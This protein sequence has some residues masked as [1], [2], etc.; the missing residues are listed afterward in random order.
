MVYKFNETLYNE[1]IVKVS[2]G[3][4]MIPNRKL[5]RVA[6]NNYYFLIDG[7]QVAK[8]PLSWVKA[9]LKKHHISESELETAAQVM[10]ENGDEVADFGIRGTL[11]LTQ[12]FEDAHIGPNNM[13]HKE[14]Q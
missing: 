5:V 7:I 2:K 3:D 4:Y 9:Q 8:G 6:D 12:K 11:I 1:Y 10:K 13:K 14:A